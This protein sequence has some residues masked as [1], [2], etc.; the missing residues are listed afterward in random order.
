VLRP[1]VVAAAD[2]DTFDYRGRI[3]RVGTADHWDLMKAACEAKFAQD[4]AARAALV[5]TGS[6]PL[7]HRT[8]KDSRTIPGV[9]RA[10][11]WMRT[12]RRIAGESPLAQPISVI[13]R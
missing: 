6:R 5:A 9:V 7:T 8:R 11:I 3:V 2:A 12:R 1:N 4:V 10:E 13:A